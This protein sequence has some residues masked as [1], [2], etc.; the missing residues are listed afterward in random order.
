MIN[1]EIEAKTSK[2]S[3]LLEDVK[4]NKLIC[5]S[6]FFRDSKIIE[7]EENRERMN[8]FFGPKKINSTKLL[9]QALSSSY[10]ID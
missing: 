5:S 7:S 9:Y 1:K 2:I 6:D 10:S 8:N 3:Q 4:E